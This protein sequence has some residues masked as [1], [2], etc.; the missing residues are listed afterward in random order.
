MKARILQNG[1]LLPAL[2]AALAQRY[3]VQP[4]WHGENPASFSRQAVAQLALDT[5]EVFFRTGSVSVSAL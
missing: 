4:L 1:H 5:L 3:D 2:E